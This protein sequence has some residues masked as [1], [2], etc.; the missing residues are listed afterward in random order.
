M[1]VRKWG[2]FALIVTGSTGA[3]PLG[4]TDAE[5]AIRQKL[6]IS[7]DER[8]VLDQGKAIAREVKTTD[9]SEIL[10]FGAIHVNGSPS[11][12]LK[13]YT[14]VEKL[15]DGKGFLAA[16]KFQNPPVLSDL[17]GLTFDKDDLEALR[18]CTP[19]DC[20]VQLPADQMEK[21]RR[22]IDW[23]SP[24]A[25]RTG[26]CA[27]PSNGAERSRDLLEGRQ[28]GTWSIPGYNPSRHT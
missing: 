3:A 25:A 12:F 28:Q 20:E 4:A 18:T 8:A 23:E 11:V 13:T 2:V 21:F 5:Q 17:A 26:E 19:G 27:R 16:K 6:N 10:V 14:E 22:T 24:Q 7:T 9:G 15:V 1:I